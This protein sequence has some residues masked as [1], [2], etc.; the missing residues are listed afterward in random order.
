MQAKQGNSNRTTRYQDL[1]AAV[2]SN[3][4]EAVRIILN[5]GDIDINA[6]DWRGHTALYVAAENGCL[7][8]ARVLVEE[9][10]ATDQ[11]DSRGYTPCF[12]AIENGHVEIV[13]IIEGVNQ[14]DFFEKIGQ[15]SQF[16][17]PVADTRCAVA[18][19]SNNKDND[20]G[21]CWSCTIS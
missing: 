12:V 20:E 6:T 1:I 14:A 17:Q 11:A 10:G 13:R 7:A 15:S 16:F 5:S 3:E 8:V 18:Y 2:L 21:C 19:N 9:Y 4:G